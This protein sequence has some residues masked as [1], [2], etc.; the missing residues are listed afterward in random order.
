MRATGVDSRGAQEDGGNCPCPGTHIPPVLRGTSAQS[1]A[2]SPHRRWSSALF[3]P[4]GKWHLGERENQLYVLIIGLSLRAGWAVLGSLCRS[5]QCSPEQCFCRRR[6]SRCRPWSSS[7]CSF[8]RKA[9]CLCTLWIWCSRDTVSIT[10]E[11]AAH[12]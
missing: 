8:F 1:H 11:F 7:I 2:R 5:A 10:T 12:S 4:L 6:I 9:M 3:L